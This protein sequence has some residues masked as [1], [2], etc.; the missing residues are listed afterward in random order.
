MPKGAANHLHFGTCFDWNNLAPLLEKYNVKIEPKTNRLL[1]NK[2]AERE[3]AI[4]ISHLDKTN[5]QL[6]KAFN[7]HEKTWPVFESSI[8]KV[9]NAVQYYKLMKEEMT[10]MCYDYIEEGN[11]DIL[12]VRYLFGFMFDENGKGITFE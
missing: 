7:R 3:D 12:E 4:D 1:I 8:W 11:C 5:Y 9:M 6:E 2:E 10:K